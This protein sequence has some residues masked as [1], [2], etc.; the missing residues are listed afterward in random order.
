MMD[1]FPRTHRYVGDVWS[2]WEWLN[3]GAFGLFSLRYLQIHKADQQLWNPTVQGD[4]DRM[5][6]AQI[7]GTVWQNCKG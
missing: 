7:S 1:Y 2:W 3:I 5:N 6:S 4:C